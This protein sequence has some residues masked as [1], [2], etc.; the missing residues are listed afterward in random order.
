[1]VL[2]PVDPK[3]IGGGFPGSGSLEEQLYRRST[4]TLAVEGDFKYDIPKH[5]GIYLPSIQVFRDSELKNGYHFSKVPRK[6]A[7][8]LASSVEAPKY[9]QKGRSFVLDP[10][11]KEEL[12]T[13]I[14]TILSVGL[15]KGHDAIVVSAFGCGFNKTPPQCIAAIFRDLLT[16]KFS[17]TYKH[18]TFAILED[19]NCLKEH[20]LGGNLVPFQQEF[21]TVSRTS[22]SK[23]SCFGKKKKNEESIKNETVAGEP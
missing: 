23:C 21:L 9:E 15:S 12:E 14:S 17:N 18:V 10:E 7:F 6:V 13:K 3:N 8:F 19:E 16:G 2:I 4:A 5:G 1:M 20:N 11:A 22:T